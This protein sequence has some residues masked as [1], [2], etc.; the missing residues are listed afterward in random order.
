M[1]A[2]PWPLT[3]IGGGRA[4]RITRGADSSHARQAYS[5]KMT[6]SKAV[7]IESKSEQVL[8]DCTDLEDNVIHITDGKE[9]EDVMLSWEE[10]D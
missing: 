1:M 6:R 3:C 5:E 9:T 2:Q 10:W 8:V 7:E 4:S